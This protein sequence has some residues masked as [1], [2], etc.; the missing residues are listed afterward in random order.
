MLISEPFKKAG[1]IMDANVA[2]RLMKAEAKLRA[3]GK[4]IDS[5]DNHSATSD[6]RGCVDSFR[7]ILGDL[8]TDSGDKSA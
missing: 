3:I 2:H 8:A 6:E 4:N 1:A 7:A 5:W